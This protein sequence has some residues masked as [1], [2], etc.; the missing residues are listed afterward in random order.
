ME[1]IKIL[2][3]LHV[4]LDEDEG[5][6]L[7]EAMSMHATMVKAMP[8]SEERDRKQKAGRSLLEKVGKQ[9]FERE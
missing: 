7:M 3:S 8:E 1:E 6:A 2:K 9:L 4:V 5:K